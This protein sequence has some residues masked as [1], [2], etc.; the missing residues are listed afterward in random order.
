MNTDDDSRL[1]DVSPPI[2]EDED[3]R[4]TMPPPPPDAPPTI[5]AL[6]YEV[7]FGNRMT[8]K[9][10]QKYTLLQAQQN[11]GIG[12]A[13]DLGRRVLALEQNRCA[14]SKALAGA[15]E[16]DL[17]DESSLASFKRRLLPV[18]KV[19]GQPCGPVQ[20]QLHPKA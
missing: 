13:D 14:A 1:T 16:S 3:D 19:L 7:R 12:D 15:T 4:T 2:E 8:E 10:L 6:L 18:V 20:E 9:L 5:E 11:R 17:A